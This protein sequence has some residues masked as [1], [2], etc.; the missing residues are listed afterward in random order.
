MICSGSSDIG[1]PQKGL[2][3]S[4]MDRLEAAEPSAPEMNA[5]R[6]ALAVAD[7]AAQVRL[8]RIACL[9]ALAFSVPRAAIALFEDG[10]VRVQ[11]KV[12]PDGCDWPPAGE[13]Q[14]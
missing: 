4:L 13:L 3:W 14:T 11:A 2:Q 12:A 6:L 8:Q 10:Q 5:S 1:R 9:A 7:P